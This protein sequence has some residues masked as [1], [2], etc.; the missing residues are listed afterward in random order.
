MSVDSTDFKKS[1]KEKRK[2]VEI[3]TEDETPTT[4]QKPVKYLNIINSRSGKFI[5]EPVTP[6]KKDKL[7]FKVTPMTP[8]NKAFRVE[9][10][11]LNGTNDPKVNKSKKRKI[12]QVEEP[13]I[14]LPKPNWTVEQDNVQPRK[15]ARNIM[16]GNTEMI[17]KPLNE[18]K[19][20]RSARD[21][22]PAELQRFRESNLYRAGIPRQ[23][24]RS[25]LMDRMKRMLSRK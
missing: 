12:V 9:K 18:K 11:D 5:E 13:A 20:I 25:L 16:T 4:P 17:V 3:D 21:L 2:F 19:R 8:V 24:S 23:D 15:R 22:I 6:E 14:V 1:K 7:G 10:L